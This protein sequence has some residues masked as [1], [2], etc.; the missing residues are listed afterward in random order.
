MTKSCNWSGRTNLNRGSPRV[1][2][3]R[4]SDSLKENS[5]TEPLV[6]IVKVSVT[7]TDRRSLRLTIS[8]NDL[9]LYGSRLN[10]LPSLFPSSVLIS[11]W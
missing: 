8:D 6:C 7:G 5:P 1:G 3:F 11:S 9:S 10:R 2:S 4:L